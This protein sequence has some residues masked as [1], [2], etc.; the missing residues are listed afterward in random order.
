MAELDIGQSSVIV[1]NRIGIALTASQATG[2]ISDNAS[3]SAGTSAA[4]GA[5]LDAACTSCPSDSIDFT[6][7][8]ADQAADESFQSASGAETSQ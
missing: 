4:L 2:Q 3:D 1:G 6:A 7:A 5:S 8:A